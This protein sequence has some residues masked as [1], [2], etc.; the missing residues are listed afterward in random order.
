MANGSGEIFGLWYQSYVAAP[1]ADVLVI[2]VPHL[3]FDWYWDDLERQAP[4]RMPEDRPSGFFD[5]VFA[6]ADY[7]IGTR[8]VY[9]AGEQP[10]YENRFRL[11]EAGPLRRVL[12]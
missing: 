2:S 3:Q 11:V 9:L 7:N 6:V 1:E 5:R 10:L 12:P 8:E 4:D